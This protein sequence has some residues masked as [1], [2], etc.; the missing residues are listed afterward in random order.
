LMWDFRSENLTDNRGLRITVHLGSQPAPFRTVLQ[1]WQDD[2]NFRS[3]FNAQ[4]ANVPYTAFRW[5][6]PPVTDA[7]ATR[8][9]E[10]V[11]LDSP[12]LERPPDQEA[13][14]AHFRGA[15]DT[16]VVVFRNLGG[17]AMMVVPCPSAAPRAYA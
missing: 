9:F 5:E 4:L 17:D 16:G 7:T 6:T 13:F 8:S 15:P 10:F 14:A 11:L 1:A 3:L 2:A 12:E